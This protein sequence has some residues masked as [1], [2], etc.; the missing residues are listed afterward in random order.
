MKFLSI[1]LLVA[2]GALAGCSSTANNNSAANAN[3]RGQNTNTG[4]LTNSDS[5]VRPAM[6]TNVTNISPPRMNTNSNT[7]S[8]RNTNMNSN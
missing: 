7:N 5:N 1:L 3:M 6:P 8:N 2:A 4:Y